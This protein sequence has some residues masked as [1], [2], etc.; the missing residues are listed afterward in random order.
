MGNEEKSNERK[1]ISFFKSFIPQFISNETAI[2]FFDKLRQSS[3]GKKF[4]DNLSKNLKNFEN[5]KKTIEKN[6]G[7]IEDQHS[8]TDMNYGNKVFQYC[9]CEVVAAF[10][11]MN[12]LTGNKDISLPLMIEY[13]E[14]DGIILSGIFGT[15]PTA[16]KDYFTFQGFETASTTMEEDYDKF[17]QIYDTFIFTFYVDK[18]N[19]FK[20]VHAV[21]I[22]KKD[23]KLTVH[24]NGNKSYLKQYNSISDFINKENNGN[25]KGI[26]LIGI[27]RKISS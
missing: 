6:N 1:D 27:K 4:P 3:S 20:Q 26:Y 25:Y 16:I 8:F 14:N 12:D 2:N 22:C 15:A 5:H 11:A 21:N 10:N 18:Y 17:G 19:I 23:G 9:G 24:N 7:F 13:F